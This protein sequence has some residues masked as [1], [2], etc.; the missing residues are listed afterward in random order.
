MMMMVVVVVVHP[1]KQLN[2]L[3]RLLYSS[4]KTVCCLCNRL[5]F[6]LTDVGLIDKTVKGSG[7]NYYT[8]TGPT[9]LQNRWWSLPAPDNPPTPDKV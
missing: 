1:I 5:R 4:V 9:K 2:S 6:M 7:Q 8:R 3:T